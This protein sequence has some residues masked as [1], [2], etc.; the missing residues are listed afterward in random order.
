MAKINITIDELEKQEK[1]LRENTRILED[2]IRNIKMASCELS[3][4]W[5]EDK[6]VSEIAENC[7]KMSV[8]ELAHACDKMTEQIGRAHV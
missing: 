7:E 4:N 1:F 3:Q 6:M 2:T 8:S 5:S